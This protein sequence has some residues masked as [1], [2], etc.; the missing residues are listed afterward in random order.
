MQIKQEDKLSITYRYQTKDIVKNYSIEEGIGIIT[1][2]IQEGA[3]RHATLFTID[4]DALFEYVNKEKT[5]FKKNLR[6]PESKAPLG[7]WG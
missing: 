3:F 6:T 7:V 1:N 5:I 4:F 2:F